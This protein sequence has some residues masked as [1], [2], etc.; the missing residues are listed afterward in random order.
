MADDAVWGD[1]ARARRN[2][3]AGDA[4]AFTG[5]VGIA[6]GVLLFTIDFYRHG[7]GR[8]PGV[9]LFAVL[10]AAGYVGLWLLPQ[11]MHTAAVTVIVVG[12]PGA[13]G[14]WILPHAH[15]FADV[16]PF[17]ILVIAAWGLCWLAPRTRG[18]TIFVA[19]VLLLLWFWVLGEVAGTD[20]YSAA[21]LPS[22]PAHTMFS[23]G[24]LTH[25]ARVV[26]VVATAD[27]NVTLAD[28]DPNDPLYPVAQECSLI[29]T[30]ACDALDVESV[31]GSDFRQFADTCGNS[32]PAGSGSRCA[33]LADNSFSSGG[34]LGVTPTPFPGAVPGE[35][36]LGRG[37]GD[38]SLQI[39]IVS[40]LFGLAYVGALALLD[41]RAWRG[42]GTAF[43]LPGLVA[44]STGTEA[45]GNA[46]K[47]A[48]VGGLLTLAAGVLIAVIGELGGRRFTTWAGGAFVAIGAYTFAG[49]VANLNDSF[50]GI[51]ATLT[52]PAFV[53]LGSGLVLVAFSYA[54]SRARP[55]APKRAAA[56]PVPAAP[57]SAAAAPPFMPP[58]PEPRPPFET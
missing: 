28:L 4:I 18:R 38:K 27:S 49:D 45:L 17:L 29:H 48:W 36:A 32:Q 5:G 55:R 2:P 39:G 21:P 13:I 6:V 3:A 58:L 30:D 19:G 54:I 23:L 34:S 57:A 12:V 26:P 42:L 7:H 33:D 40:L 44:L 1:R 14:W 50:S 52:R 43:V 37:A 22:P 56:E 25:P 8:P 41:R 9:A 16:R 51:G 24:A 20:A 11:E 15:R 46:A 53:I 47:H 31:P 10:I 35:A